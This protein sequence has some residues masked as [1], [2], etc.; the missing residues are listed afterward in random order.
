MS[1][2]VRHVDCRVKIKINNLGDVSSYTALATV[3]TLTA[4]N[5]CKLTAN[6]IPRFLGSLRDAEGAAITEKLLGT[7]A[8]KLYRIT[9]KDALLQMHDYLQIDLCICI[10][11]Y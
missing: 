4:V 6:V 10:Y 1:H 11:I 5:N 3:T 7:Y 2:D 8:H 9:P